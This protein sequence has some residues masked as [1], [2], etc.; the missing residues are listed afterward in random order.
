MKKILALLVSLSIIFSGISAVAA[1]S[2]AITNFNGAESIS[3]NWTVDGSGSGIDITAQSDALKI[4]SSVADKANLRYLKHSATYSEIGEWIL[5]FRFKTVG[6]I[7]SN[8]LV[9]PVIKAGYK[10]TSSASTAY[11]W[12]NLVSLS[13]SAFNTDGNWHTA[14]YDLNFDEKKYELYVQ[15]SDGTV[16]IIHSDYPLNFAEDIT[17]NSIVAMELHPYVKGTMYIDDIVVSGKNAFAITDPV[18]GAKLDSDHGLHVAGTIPNG[19]AE[20]SARVMIDGQTIATLANDLDTFDVV[21]PCADIASF[22]NGSHTVTV[23]A[24]YVGGTKKADVQVDFASNMNTSSITID[25]SVSK[26]SKTTVGLCVDKAG[27]SDGAMYFKRTDGETA[28]DAYIQEATKHS[29]VFVIETDIKFDSG[30]KL[31]LES[32]NSSSTYVWLGF[33]TDFID[34]SGK[35]GG[36]STVLTAGNWYNIRLVTDTVSYYTELYVDDKLV[37]SGTNSKLKGTGISLVK[38]QVP[39]TTSGKAVYLDNTKIYDYVSTP[40]ADSAAYELDGSMSVAD[41][42]VISALA[43]KIQITMSSAFDS[44]TADDVT[45]NGVEALA[46][47]MDSN[48]ITVTLSQPLGRNTDVELEFASALTVGG[49]AMS[50]PYALKLKTN[51][52]CVDAISDIVIDSDKL[53]ASAVVTKGTY[54]SQLGESAVLIVAAYRQVGA[55]LELTALT[56][57]TKTLAEGDNPIEAALTSANGG[58][59]IKAFLWNNTSAAIPLK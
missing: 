14:I 34:A 55:G 26:S 41:G 58:T 21:I 35:I 22:A 17:M 12:K 24:D 43:E 25:T 31:Q 36:S 1:P 29:G 10:T 18:S 32:K 53:T 33:A 52:D 44:V 16:R 51:N 56:P 23:C 20:G 2:E 27:N 28:G 50:K 42:N 38:F 45:I 9:T 11:E 3:G 5:S 19:Y 59:V 8:F 15:D 46:V 54:T 30:A 49:K 48:V 40:S 57:V 47:T 39:S 4:V 13:A 7:D 37:K 6:T